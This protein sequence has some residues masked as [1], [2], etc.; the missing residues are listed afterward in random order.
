MF[1][2]TFEEQMAAPE[3]ANM[4]SLTANY[5]SPGTPFEAAHLGITSSEDAE[6][7]RALVATYAEA[8]VTWWLENFTPQRGKGSWSNWPLEQMHRRVRQGPPKR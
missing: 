2:Q 8:G 4:L 5:R 1:S 7:D 6:Q 3:I